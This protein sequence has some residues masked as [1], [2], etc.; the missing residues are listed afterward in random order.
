MHYGTI[1]ERDIANGEGVR[2]SLFVSG[3]RRRCADCFNPMT[4]DFSYGAAF[5]PAVEQQ[6]L[7][8]LAPAHIAGLT[9]LGGEPMEIENQADLLPFLQK[10]K[11]R[12][13]EKTIWLFS[14]YVFEE[15]FLSGG[16][17]FTE[18]TTPLLQLVDVLVDGPF[19]RELKQL[20]LS[21]RGSSNQRLLNMPRSLASGRG[22]AR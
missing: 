20:S 11:A 6:V 14:G 19:I 12:Y 17:Q 7:D 10:V 9:V 22:I 3:C 13:P 1:K 18:H 8:S 21:F 16:S 5:T 4:W 15:H 2:T